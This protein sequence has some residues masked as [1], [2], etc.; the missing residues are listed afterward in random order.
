[1]KRWRVA[2]WIGLGL[3]GGFWGKAG[4]RPGEN[5]LVNGRFD[6]V[7]E[8]FPQFWTP[9]PARRV[10]YLPAGGP[11]GKMPAV[12]LR[13][14]GPGSG[15]VSLRQQ[16][17]V[18]AAGERYRLRAWIKTRGFRSSHAGVIIHN[19][20]WFKEAGFRNLPA[21]SEWTHR[22]T[23][24]T[25]F[26]SRNKQ[27]GLA[28]FGVGMRGE[29]Y[30]AGLELEAVSPGAL[31]G[32]SS[33]LT[34]ITRPRLVPLRPLLGRIPAGNPHLTLRLCG[35][36]PV[37]PAA[38]ECRFSVAGAPIPS[39]RF[40]LAGKDFRLDLHGLRPGAYSVRVSVFRRAG[41]EPLAAATFPIGVVETP[42][43]DR[44]GIRRL[45][46]LVSELLNRRLAA[47]APEAVFDFANPRDGWVF[48]EIVPEAG[49]K[50]RGRAAVFIDGARVIGEGAER[51]ET[52]RALGAGPHRIAVRG[53]LL[54][55][56][57]LVVR[58]V[59][60]IL[61]YPPCTNSYVP[62]NGAY[63]W[64]FMK[65]HILYAVT[66]LNGGRLPGEALGE[67]K[68]MG[69]RWLANF[70][71]APMNDASD[72]RRR[73]ESAAG[74]TDPRYDGVTCDELF[75][76]RATIANYTQALRMV[77]NPRNR[78]IYTWIVGKPS[79]AAVDT[80]FM[81][82]ALNASG[83]RGR[84]LV[85]AYCRPQPDENAAAAWLDEH[86]ADTMR[87]FNAFFPAAAAGTGIIFGNFTQIP[88]ISLDHDPAVDFKYYLDMQV[89]LIATDPAFRGLAAT[90]YWGTYYGDEEIVRWSFRLMR[91]YA[92]E[93]KRTML[94][95]QYG[96]RYKPGFLVNGDFARGLEGW[97]VEPAGKGTI[98]VRTLPGYGKKSEGRWGAGTAGDTVCVLS[99]RAGRPN[100][101]RQQVH[102][103]ENGK[104]Y[105]LQFVTADLDDVVAGKYN[106]RRYGIRVELPG[107]R[108]LR[109]RSYVYIDRRHA[110]R[111]KS[112]D[113]VG[114]INLVRIVFRATRPTLDLTFHDTPA[115]P[116]ENL[117]LNYVQLKPYFLGP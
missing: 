103:L 69:L 17:M 21:D 82:A 115:H 72:I 93:G 114:Q 73:L 25:L 88:I 65:K 29:L 37:K 32:S 44:R 63:D 108:V 112:N 47:G 90:G 78:L 54:G 117:I 39:R 51:P 12:V 10:R 7:I 57:R 66:T 13:G 9:S 35:L 71:V 49:G 64:G 89:H 5:L 11:Q 92:V 43:I 111:Y 75:F 18:L 62:G 38:C 104:P 95:K 30:V 27:Y 106:P 76:G 77:R 84:L 58:S 42:T 40:P 20:G 91:H 70:A 102:G 48:A 50:L 53:R 116:G 80:D 3:L 19:D 74:M 109:D 55:G 67:A 100:R 97:R 98:R 113:N 107:V 23:E 36:L 83:G 4:V 26:P 85:E 99:R 87:R 79:V 22:E 33:Q 16:G 110:G 24:F 8:G 56:A 28:V 46:N 60:E 68:A 101:L 45:N 2:A 41:G 6:H 105:C 15:T 31:A 81:S 96:F 59:P 14:G 61:D 1:M 34:L 86:V 94:S 52:F